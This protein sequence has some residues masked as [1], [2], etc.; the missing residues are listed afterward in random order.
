MKLP[1]AVVSNAMP[2]LKKMYRSVSEVS[3]S[4]FL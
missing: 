1:N 3:R 4:L 2:K